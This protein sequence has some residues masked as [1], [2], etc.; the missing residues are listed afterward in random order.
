MRIRRQYMISVNSSQLQH[1]TTVSHSTLP[2]S[3]KLTQRSA[4]SGQ[5]AF[6]TM[7]RRK[8]HL[9]SHHNTVR[10]RWRCSLV[11]AM[12]ERWKQASVQQWKSRQ[13]NCVYAPRGMLSTHL[14]EQRE[15][16]HMQENGCDCR[17]LHQAIQRT[18][19][20][21]SHVF[22]LWVIGFI[23]ELMQAY[24]AC[25]YRRSFSEECRN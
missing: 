6:V 13:R 1:V 17:W 15:I 2:Q 11:F 12:S 22:F 24:M 18:L 5:H 7:W 9:P 4:Q 20:D 19:R 8:M 10:S 3:L 21:R 23:Y 16:G 25:E 14:E